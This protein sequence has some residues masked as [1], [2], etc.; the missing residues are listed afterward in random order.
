MVKIHNLSDELKKNGVIA[1]SAGNHAQAVAFAS[2]FYDIS[3]IIVCPKM[4]LLVKL[5]LQSRT[6]PK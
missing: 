5:L 3:C 1:S 4:H 6:G 2:K